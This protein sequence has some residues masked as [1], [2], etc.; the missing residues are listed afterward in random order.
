MLQTHFLHTKTK[1]LSGPDAETTVLVKLLSP[2]VQCR[3]MSL[4]T[5]LSLENSQ[6]LWN[7]SSQSKTS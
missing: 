7:N 3:V 2:H 6:L 5:V 1:L 4:N